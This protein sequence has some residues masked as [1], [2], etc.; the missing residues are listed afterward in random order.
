[1]TVK[2][3]IRNL[4]KQLSASDLEEVGAEVTE[5]L[6]TKVN[7]PTFFKECAEQRFSEGLV[8]PRCGK[9]HIVKAGRY[10]KDKSRQRFQCQ[11]CR[12]TFCMN[13][14]TIFSHTKLRMSDWLKYAKCVQEGKTLRECAKEVG[15][16]LK[17]SFYMRHK[18]LSAFKQSIGIDH[19]SGIIEMDETFF[20]ESFKGNHKKHNPEWVAPRDSGKSSKRGKEVKYR[21]ISHELLCLATGMDRNGGIVAVPL[22]MGRATTNAL[23]GVYGG[24]VEKGSTVCTDSN[25]AYRRLAE[26]LSVDLIQIASGKHKK[27]VYHINNINSLHNRLKKWLDTR[28]GIA[29]KYVGNY[30]YWFNW[31][32][33][34][35]SIEKHK[36]GRNIIYLC[37]STPLK[38]TQEMVRLTLPF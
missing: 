34:N 19:L 21:G 28:Y 5:M 36:K 6:D 18:I 16:C 15:V 8:C 12:K 31:L 1:M 11:D 24:N 3:E 38:M 17:T 9:K 7:F 27:G 2:D 32:E 33:R 22:C 26:T 25:S 20:A 4:L 35:G 30:A 13:T 37:M 14:D 29:T 10:G 23:L